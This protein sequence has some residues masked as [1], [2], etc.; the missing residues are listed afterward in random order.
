MTRGKRYNFDADTVDGSSEQSEGAGYPRIHSEGNETFG[1]KNLIIS[2]LAVASPAS[3]P[4]DTI[5]QGVL[6]EYAGT[7]RG[8]VEEILRGLGT[9]EV[10]L[11]I[12]ECGFCDRYRLVD[13]LSG[14]ADE[15]E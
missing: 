3:L 15:N 11:M 5:F 9:A 13:N 7:A 10:T 8:D 14:G 2:Q 4:L 1:I 12:S 6:C